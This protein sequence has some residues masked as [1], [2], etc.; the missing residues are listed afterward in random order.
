MR[1]DLKLARPRVS[2]A[3]RRCGLAAGGEEPPFDSLS[4]LMIERMEGNFVGLVEAEVVRGAD[5]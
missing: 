4:E 3:P 5:P 2:R 1:F